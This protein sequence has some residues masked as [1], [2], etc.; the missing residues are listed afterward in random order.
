MPKPERQNYVNIPEIIQ[1][2]TYHTFLGIYP[3][4]KLLKISSAF[5]NGA[6]NQTVDKR[7]SLVVRNRDDFRLTYGLNLFDCFG[8]NISEEAECLLR[9]QLQVYSET[10]PTALKTSNIY[11]K[12]F[13]LILEINVSFR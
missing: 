1:T 10:S 3:E 4:K 11:H 6:E 2:S 7:T 9:K 8:T 5:N 12:I 13:V